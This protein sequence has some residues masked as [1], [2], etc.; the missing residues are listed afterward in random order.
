MSAVDYPLSILHMATR[1]TTFWSTTNVGEAMPGV[2]TPLSWTVWSRSSE[3]GGRNAFRQI[4]ALT[5]DEAQIPVDERDRFIGICCGRVC[6]QVDFFTSMGDRLPGTSAT[7][8]AEQFMGTVPPELVSRPTKRRY[9]VVAVSLPR[10]FVGVRRRVLTAHR[11]IADWWPSEVA[12][13]PTLDL[14]GARYQFM[15]ARARFEHAMALQAEGMFIGVQPVYDQLLALI[16]RAD[17]EHLADALMAGGGSHAETEMVDGLWAVAHGRLGIGDF[18]AEHGF[19]GP[20]EGEISG[21]VWR[22]DTVP[23]RKLVQQYAARP[24]GE[25]PALVAKRRREERAA[26][27]AELLARLGRVHRGPARA[28]LALARRNVPIRGIGKVAFLRALDVARCA[29]RRSGHL[30]AAGGFIDDPEDVFYFTAD[31]LEGRLPSDARDVIA[32]RKAERTTFQGLTLPTH[33]RGRP[34]MVGSADGD[35]RPEPGYVITA[36]GGSGGVAQGRVRVV[37]DPTFTDVEPD[38]VIVARTT[39]PSWA[40]IMF[41]SRALVVDIGGPLSHAAIVARELGVPCVISTHNGTE[42]LRTG[43]LVRVDGTAGTVEI[44]ELAKSHSTRR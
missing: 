36:I 4:G 39:D 2:P 12:R 11:D 38:E 27:E 32:A 43:D 44:L 5:D 15:A 1:P 40:S 26:A 28:V 33:W 41:L 34:E 8:I 35:V 29:A 3:R 21:R 9:P 23:V 17:A 18:L 37:T 13:T 25:D 24:D 6:A 19:H 22:E 31:E 10:A 7:A 42:I 14:V 16:K 20:L 30:M